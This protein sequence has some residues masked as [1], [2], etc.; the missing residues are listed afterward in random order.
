MDEPNVPEWVIL[1]L[2]AVLPVL[3][4]YLPVRSIAMGGG[5]ILQARWNH[6]ISEDIGL[7]VHSDVFSAVIRSSAAQMEHDLYQVAEV[8]KK[9]LGST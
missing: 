8:D 1:R 7:F 3:C 9:D 2:N 6:R 4:R 5:T